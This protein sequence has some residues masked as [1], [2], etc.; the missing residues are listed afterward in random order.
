VSLAHDTQ[1]IT[2]NLYS[3]DDYL[4]RGQRL[5][6]VDEALRLQSAAGLIQVYRCRR[7]LK[8]EKEVRLTT[9]PTSYE[10]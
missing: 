3:F 6:E 5:R 10:D 8:R 7:I 4:E 2:D 1:C 9:T